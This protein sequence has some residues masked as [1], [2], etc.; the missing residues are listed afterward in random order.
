MDEVDVLVV[1]ARC[2]G[3]TLAGFLRRAGKSVVVVDSCTMPSDQ[4]LSTHFVGPVGMAVLDD[5]GVGDKVRAFAPEIDL[6]INGIEETVARIAMPPGKRG[7]CPRRH[8]L[9]ALLCEAARAAGAQVRL[10]TKLV[11]LLR[12]GDRVVGGVVEHDGRREEIR[13][14]LVVGADG[15]NSKVAQLVGAEEYHG[16]DSPRAAYWAYWPRPSW[17]SSDPRFQGA[18]CIVHRGEDY[19]FIFPANRDQILIG[20]SFPIERIP[21]WKGD[22]KTKLLETVRGYALTAPLTAGEP[23]GSV[24]GILKARFFFRRAAGPGWALVGDA[25]LFKDPAPG[26]GITDAFRDARALARAIVAGGDEAL[27]RYWR[28]RDVSSYELFEFARNMGQPGYNNLLNHVIF[29][30]LGRRQDLRDRMV[31][32]QNRQLSPFAAFTT[33]E[34]VRW[35][36]GALLRGKV[37][38]LAPFLDAGKRGAAV[39][40]ELASKQRL[41]QAAAAAC[42]PL[43]QAAMSPIAL[44]S[45]R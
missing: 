3:A 14:A 35:V 5:L 37:G 29:T 27:V 9:D 1:G 42:A 28:E 16:Y 12:Q 20:L 19:F 7:T 25:G 4:P 24:V 44:G 38:V 21:D 33:G 10:R 32:V 18:A 45:A 41:A 22:P 2:A 31:A 26:L 43:P 17:Y 23:L 13:A 8:D 30:K 40:T 34:I 36:L 11:E 6:F 15:R 39:K